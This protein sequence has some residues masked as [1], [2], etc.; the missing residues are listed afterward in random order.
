MNEA[1]KFAF[2]DQGNKGRFVARLPGNSD[3][4]EMTFSRA[5]EKLIIVDRTGVPDSM[6]GQGVGKALAAHVG[7][8]ARANG[9]KIIPLCP[10]LKAQ[11]DRH[12]EWSDVIQG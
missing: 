2:E 9:T 12:P 4:A 7:G 3:E 8:Y 11:S 1:I 10:F 5:N 6:A